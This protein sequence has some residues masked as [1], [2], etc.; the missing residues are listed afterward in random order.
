MLEYDLNNATLNINGKSAA[1]NTAY[2]VVYMGMSLTKTENLKSGVMYMV[3]LSS[4]L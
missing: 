4:S 2:G 1:P 3:I